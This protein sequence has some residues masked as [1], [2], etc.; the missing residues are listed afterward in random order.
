MTLMTVVLQK[1]R[2]SLHHPLQGLMCGWHAMVVP[3]GTVGPAKWKFSTRLHHR[4]NWVA[5]QITNN[6]LTMS[7]LSYYGIITIYQ[8]K[9]MS[10]IIVTTIICLTRIV[11]ILFTFRSVHMVTYCPHT[12]LS[13]MNIDL[14][15]LR[16]VNWSYVLRSGLSL[17][18]MVIN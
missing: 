5:A 18:W 14:N 9:W 13:Q 10:I 11:S 12:E 15:L 17:L 2:V 3:V 8:L 16:S 1:D 4:N 7:W 6:S